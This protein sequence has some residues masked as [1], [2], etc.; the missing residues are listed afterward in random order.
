ML[1]RVQSAINSNFSIE[2]KA[3]PS[4]PVYPPDLTVREIEILK[5]VAE[6]ATDKEIAEH[7]GIAIRTASNHVGAILKKTGV[8]SRQSLIIRFGKQG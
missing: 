7:Y 5:K 3:P 1:E 2:A 6:G 8:S 4:E